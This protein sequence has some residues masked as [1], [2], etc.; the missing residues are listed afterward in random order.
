MKYGYIRVS[1]ITQNI[2][3]QLVDMLK[4]GI[5]KSNIFVDYQSGKNFKREYYQKLKS[6][7]KPNDELIIKS[8][9]RLGRN[10]EM[11]IKDWNEI[12]NLLNVNIYV[13]DMPI[14]NTRTNENNLIRKFISDIVLQILSFVAENERVNIKQRQKEG[15][16][17]AKEKGKIF[18][19]PKIVLPNKFSE[20]VSKYKNKEISL[21]NVLI[22][23]GLKKST[24]Y[25][26][27]KNVN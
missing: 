4:L 23:L 8:I 1:S 13:I 10:Y 12:V 11:I 27:L 5:L 18:G 9:D 20:V 7:L 16:K 24:F 14:L 25:N 26:K 15:I 22:E 6:K 2:D 17:I 3:R 19:R 21:S